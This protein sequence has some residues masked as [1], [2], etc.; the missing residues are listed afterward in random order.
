MAS[1]PDALV[2]LGA[3]SWGTALAMHLAKKHQTVFLWGRNAE[4]IASIIQTNYNSRYLSGLSLSNNIIPTTDLNLVANR[5]SKF[6]IAVPSHAFSSTL[7]TL[8]NEI[9]LSDKTLYFCCGTK[10]IDST[11]GEFLHEIF[12]QIMGQSPLYGV[13]SGPSFANEIVAQLP[14]AL[15]LASAKIQIANQFASWFRTHPI[16]IYTTTDLVGVQLGG[17]IKNIVAIAAGISDGLQLGVNARSALITRGL[18]EMVRIGIALGG[19]IET[20]MGLA[21]IGDIVL[22]CTDNQSRNRRLGI[23]LGEGRS[24]P[25]VLKEI[26][27]EAEG[28]NSARALFDKSIALR[29]ELPITEQIYRILFEGTNPM[30]AVQNLLDRE[31]QPE[32]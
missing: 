10:G 26:N 24:L 18:A 4:H 30:T 19:Q 22:T 27:Q 21:G 14:A 1:S 16:R 7:V 13:L 12:R 31:P 28:I 6:V 11:N 3:G 29:I 32:N 5:A 8:K 9:P 20:F 17:A 15:T 23:G 25:E 2:V